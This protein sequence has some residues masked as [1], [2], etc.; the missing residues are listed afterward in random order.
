M[1][2]GID[3]GTTRVV[4]ASA[5]RGNYPIVT[6]E[7][8]NGEGCEWYP[9]LLA[10]R[11]EDVR[12]GHEAEAVL[13]DSAWQ[14]LRA[15]KRHLGIA[16]PQDRLLG[17]RVPELAARFLSMLREALSLRSNLGA[18][19]DEPLEVA[20][21]VP[22]HASA[23]QRLL[24]ADAFTQAGFR[25][26]RILDEPSA[27]G[28]EYAWRRP[29]DAQVRRR[30]IAVYDLGGGTFDASII[31]MSDVLHEVITTEGV[32][33]LGGEDFDA[34]LLELACRMAD[35][36]EPAEGA[37]RQRMLEL[38]RQEKERI[39][40]ATRRISPDLFADGTASRIPIDEYEAALRP[41][42]D[43]SLEALD[44]ALRRVAERAGQ[45][46]ERHTVVYQVGGASQLPA[47]GRALRERFGRRVWRSPYP[48]ASVAIGLAI[49][50]EEEHS[51]RIAGSLTR[52]FGVWRERDAGRNAS[53]DL[54]FEKDVPL[55]G[56]GLDRM[57]RV[58]RYRAHHNIGHFRF[59]E[60]SRLERGAPAGDV[61]PWAEVRSPLVAELRDR[62][63]DG[64]EVE[65]L[66]GPGDEVEERYLCDGNGIIEVEI[67]N[68][69]AGYRS[70][71]RPTV[72]TA[73]SR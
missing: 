61:T 24:T 30:H 55:P 46:V 2:L 1:R 57:V 49:A 8:P 33:R 4:V 10:L 11:G 43:R 64:V 22:A 7:T 18:R 44:A 62:P 65:R 25:V 34:A 36:P 42:I 67:V 14:P 69:T 23:N 71:Y 73:E 72:D 9:S 38:C 60:C 54:I 35:R 41:L 58:R 27:A 32:S 26:L 52:H 16:G 5:D 17:W 12:G 68:V 28:L 3:F 70:A 39:T 48:H 19:P 37:E 50:A 40:S 20:I 29:A 21:A 6:F 59:V 13:G 45:E 51:P 63:L 56:S 47:V 66:S 53:F 15:V 31:A